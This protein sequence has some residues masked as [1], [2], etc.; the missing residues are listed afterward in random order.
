M[1]DVKRYKIDIMVDGRPI[2]DTI[3]GITLSKYDIVAFLNGLTEENNRLMALVN[4][5]T[6]DS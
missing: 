3:A 1:S 2:I 6:E 5:H 4:S